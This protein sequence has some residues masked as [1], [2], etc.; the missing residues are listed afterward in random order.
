MTRHPL[1][2]WEMVADGVDIAQRELP[3]QERDL[4]W[5]GTSALSPNGRFLASA[6]GTHVTVWCTKV[7][8][9][10]HNLSN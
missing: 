10:S 9:F 7:T 3:L 2:V 6:F 4:L 5:Y 8:L 1:T